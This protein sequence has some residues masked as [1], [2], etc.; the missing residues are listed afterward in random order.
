MYVMVQIP[1]DK[2]LTLRGGYSINLS[3]VGAVGSGSDKLVMYSTNITL[4]TAVAYGTNITN[5]SLLWPTAPT[6]LTLPITLL[7]TVTYGT[8]ITNFTN[9]T[10]IT[11]VAAA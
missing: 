2:V 3:D 8:N 1:Y 10:N 7:A 9:F 11:T 6:L 4:V 5:L